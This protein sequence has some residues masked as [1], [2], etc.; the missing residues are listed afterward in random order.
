MNLRHDF[1]PSGVW[2]S[3]VESENP[4]NMVGDSNP[5]GHCPPLP[6]ICSRMTYRPRSESFFENSEILWVSKCTTGYLATWI[7][8]PYYFEG[9]VRPNIFQNVEMQKNTYRKHKITQNHPM[10]QFWGEGNKNRG[11][12]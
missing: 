2:P 12:L 7:H 3:R 11:G 9:Y 8:S 5:R 4:S 1:V 6:H 10:Q